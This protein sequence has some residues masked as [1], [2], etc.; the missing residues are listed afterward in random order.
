MQ[1][2]DEKL[3]RAYNR[4]LKNEKAGKIVLAAKA[5]RECLELDPVDFGGAAVRLASLGQG[6]DPDGAPPAYVATLFDQ[7]ADVFDDIL[8]EQ[9]GYAVPL[10]VPD[11]LTAL[12]LERFSRMLDLGCGTGL[13]GEA[14]RDRVD[15]IIGVDLSEAILGIADERGCYDDLYLGEAV[16][17]V[18]G[19][20]EAPFDLITATDVLPYLG[21][22]AVMFEGV[23][24]ALNT[25]GVF[26]FSTETLSDDVFG[27]R[28]WKVGP[29]QRFH[30]KLSYVEA[31]LKV[32]GLNVLH[33][34]VIVVRTDEGQPQYGHLVMAGKN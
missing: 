9:L 1:N 32:A 17:F 18:A 5:Y 21:S 26:V 12:K 30:H 20:D 25:A 13:T 27:N 15:T 33:C 3:T 4:G 28:D 34:E 24:K 14:M 16:A 8:V 10:M 2:D 29:H 23:A 31:V 7:H 11:R 6:P 22:L 19:W